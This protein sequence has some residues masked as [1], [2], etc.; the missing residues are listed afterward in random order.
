MRKP[1]PV[2]EPELRA[3]VD[4]AFRGHRSLSHAVS[5]GGGQINDTRLITLTDG[6]RCVLRV[7]SGDATAAA[8]PG[9]F[10]P[11]GLRREA[12]VI[13]AAGLAAYMP[14]TIAHDFDRRVIDRDWVIQEAMPGRPLADVETMLSPEARVQVWSQVGEL[15]RALHGVT[16]PWF[17]PPSFGSTFDR[18]TALLAHD[19]DGFISDA[20]RFALDA[21]PFARLRQAIDDLR[22][23]LDEVTTPSLIHSD[24]SPAHIFV[25]VNRAGQSAVSGLIDLEF[26]RFA[27]PLS[28]SLFAWFEQERGK[29]A[30]RSAFL[31][32]YGRE[33]LTEN[34]R[35]RIRFYV[36]LSL[37]WWATLL[38]WQRRPVADV[39]TELTQSL[40][41]I[42]R[43]TTGTIGDAG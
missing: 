22:D 36:A 15:T 19:V 12:A 18:W 40:D 32:G 29:E 16:A 26:G 23:V 11:Y 39:M 24:L 10:T 13:A 27:D 30:P 9:W 41:T 5:L 34:E 33:R 20:E 38:A 4:H 2:N 35:I 28:E 43:L 6:L 17:G 37:G 3:I 25:D 7:A 8:A 1:D 31:Q 42:D 21:Q 14:V